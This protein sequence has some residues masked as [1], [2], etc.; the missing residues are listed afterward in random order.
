MR[1]RIL[2]LLLCGAIV[3]ACAPRLRA[4]GLLQTIDI[5][6]LLPSTIS[7][8][9]LARTIGIRWDARSIP[10]RYSLN[11]TLDPVP[12]PL[13]A[14]VLTLADTSPALQRAL[15]SWNRI[16]TSFIE[17]RITGSTDNPS[18][19]GFDMVNEITFRTGATFAAIASSPSVSLIADTALVDGDDI[20]GDGDADVSNAIAV[21]T[22]V[23]GDGDLEL[24][25]GL[26]KAGTILDNDV[27]FNTKAA[28]GLRFTVD[29]SADTTTRSVDLECVAVHEFGHSLG[30]S[31]TLTNQASAADG[32]GATM[33]PFIDTGDP[34][35]ELS[36]RSLDV[37]DIAWASYVY[38]EGTAASGPAA[39]AAGDVA[40]SQVYG[41]IKGQVTHGVQN[42]PLAGAHLFTVDK[43]SGVV[44]VSAFSGTTNLSF[45][46]ATGGLFFVPEQAV[47]IVDGA[48]EIPVPKGSYIVG[49]EPVDG[50]PVPAGSISYTT[51]VGNY[52]GQMNFNEEFWNNNKEATVELRPWQAKNVAVNPGQVAAGVNI[53]TTRAVNINNFGPLAAIGFINSPGGR[54]YAVRVPAAQIAEAASGAPFLL[55]GGLFDTYVVDAST[56]ALYSEALLT[57]GTVDP[58]T[59]A[60][61]SLDLSQPLVSASG[62]LGQDG[63]FAPLFTHDP[64][65][66][67]RLVAAGIADGSIENLFLVL[68]IPLSTPYPGVSGQPPLVG[69]ST[70]APTAGLSYFSN[71]GVTWNLRTDFDIRFSLVL[72]EETN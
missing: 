19:A 11:S 15:D 51:L 52:F 22:D 56:P 50:S 53:S 59:S 26:Y 18:I 72:S 24:P 35:S 31:H 37:D 67:G 40:F 5:T 23:D 41:L 63:D 65:D 47:A 21:T 10:V 30:L 71:D 46:P 44:R 68:R 57:R 36:V 27:Q 55:H 20:D 61:T 43:P 6:A 12:N 29:D 8:H 14:P 64:H 25:A 33:F 70:A 60:I 45:D 42:R 13:G 39:L 54:Y 48:Y 16:P 3:L 49:I 2:P 28:G 17:M 62:F 69:L 58:V 32:T 9:L 1:T 66:L 4:G 38:P 34:A 7:G